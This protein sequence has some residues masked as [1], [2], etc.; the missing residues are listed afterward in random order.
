MKYL[1]LL[2]G[3]SLS[4]TAFARSSTLQNMTEAQ[5]LGAWAGM[6]LACNAGNRLDDYELIA[7]RIIGNQAASD[8]DRMKDFKEYAAEKLRTFNLQRKTPAE[9]CSQVLAHFDELPIFKSTVY[10]DGSVKLPNGKV[11]SA[12]NKQPQAKRIYMDSPTD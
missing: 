7:S 10:Q 4:C 9:P 5:Q 12:K 11:L 6:A 2:L 8:E 3:L 1:L